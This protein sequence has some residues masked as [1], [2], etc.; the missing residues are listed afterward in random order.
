LL[1]SISGIVTA[2][3]SAYIYKINCIEQPQFYKIP[4]DHSI[5]ELLLKANEIS[6]PKSLEELRERALIEAQNRIEYMK[7]ERLTIDVNLLHKPAPD[8]SSSYEELRQTDNVHIAMNGYNPEQLKVLRE[9]VVNN[10]KLLV[11][12]EHAND[13]LN[14]VKGFIDSIADSSAKDE[15]VTFCSSLDNRMTGMRQFVSEFSTIDAYYKDR[16]FHTEYLL[17]FDTDTAD[18]THL[19]VLA[20]FKVAFQH[21]VFELKKTTS[22]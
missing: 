7:D 2:A 21:H 6:P 5:N 8:Y 4:R 18:I 13:N 17:K 19:S 16:K 20:R 15:L 22:T 9:V 14:K 11:N 3:A 10:R 1:F 12:L